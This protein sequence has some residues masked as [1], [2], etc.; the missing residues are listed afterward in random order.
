[1]PLL[2]LICMWPLWVYRVNTEVLSTRTVSYTA[3]NHPGLQALMRCDQGCCAVF[4]V[5]SYALKDLSF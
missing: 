1:M 2:L 5:K 3:Q 4:P